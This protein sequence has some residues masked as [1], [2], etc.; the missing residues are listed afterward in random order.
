L[1]FSFTNFLKQKFY[2]I[3]LKHCNRLKTA[4]LER[5]LFRVRIEVEILFEKQLAGACEGNHFSK[6]LPSVSSA[7][8]LG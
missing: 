5:Y 2:K 3:F 7:F 6:R 4:A 8:G 1:I